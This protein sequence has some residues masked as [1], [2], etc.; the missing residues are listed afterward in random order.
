MNF[1]WRRIIGA[2]LVVWGGFIF[3]V[4]G[5]MTWVG[6]STG[7]DRAPVAFAVTWYFIIGFI[8]LVSIAMVAFGIILTRRFRARA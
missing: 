8:A 2:A 3:I 5:L 4:C 6:A 7:L 1:D